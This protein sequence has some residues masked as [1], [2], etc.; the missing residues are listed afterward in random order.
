MLV[1]L[2]LTVASFFFSYLFIQ[3]LL[4]ILNFTSSLELYIEDFH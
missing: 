3:V 2:F 1:V 4:V